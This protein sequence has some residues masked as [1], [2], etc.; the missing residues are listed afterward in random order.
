MK[1]TITKTIPEVKAKPARVVEKEIVLCDVCEKEQSKS[2]NGMGKCDLCDRDVCRNSKEKYGYPYT[3]Y[4]DHPEDYG[5][6][7]RKVCTMCLPLYE[8]DIAPLLLRHEEE[9]EK[10]LDKLKKESQEQ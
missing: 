1:K 10:A 3:C 9:E 8:R 7:P 4:G 6:Y 2:Y 5:D